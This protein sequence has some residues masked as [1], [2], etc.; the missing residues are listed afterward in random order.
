MLLTLF[1]G[2]TSELQNIENKM[3]LTTVG[4]GAIKLELHLNVRCR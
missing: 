1:V 4:N 2:S 3:A